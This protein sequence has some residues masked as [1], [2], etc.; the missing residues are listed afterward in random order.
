[1]LPAKANLSRSSSILAS[2]G[3]PNH[4]L[5]PPPD[6]PT[7]AIGLTRSPP[8]HQVSTTFQPPWSSGSFLA[9][10]EVLVD[11]STACFL[12]GMPFAPMF[13]AATRPHAAV[14]GVSFGRISLPFVTSS[15]ASRLPLLVLPMPPRPTV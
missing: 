3:Q 2:L 11:P 13:F 1:M 6:R 9:R 14:L 7:A 8:I 15:P 5:S 10:R 12:T 4:A